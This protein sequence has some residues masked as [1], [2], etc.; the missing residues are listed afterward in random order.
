MN[1]LSISAKIVRIEYVANRS[2]EECQPNLK[3]VTEEL[4]IAGIHNEKTLI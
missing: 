4:E 3:S 1:D 2:F